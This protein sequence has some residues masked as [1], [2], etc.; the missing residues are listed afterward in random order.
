LA[1]GAGQ[2]Y[3]QQEIIK[4]HTDLVVID[5][6]VLKRK[7]GEIVNG[8]NAADFEL[9]ED[10]IRQQI[11]H[12]SQDQLSLSVILLIDLSGSVSP[13]LNEIRDGALVALNRLRE[14]DEVAVLAFST[15]TQL[16]QDF[17]TERR[18]VLNKISQ[19]DKTPLIGQGTLLYPALRD[20]AVHMSKASNPTSRRVIIA[21]TDN[22]SWDY[23]GF[24]VSEKE[25]SDQ[26]IGSG[27][28]VCGLVVEGSL[29]GVE[30]MLR[31]GG[32]GKDIYRR[33]MTIDPF[34]TQTGGEVIKSPSLEINA[35]LAQ[36]VD[37]LRTRYSLGF[38]PKR[39][40]ADGGYRQIRLIL[41]P[42]TN[43]RLGEVVIKTK[44][45]Y[46]ARP[47]GQRAQDVKPGQG[48]D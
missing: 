34:A 12:F 27:S 10:G 20:A 19:I 14:K 28:M 9:Y 25:V 47:R 11:T 1:A 43:K 33:R 40:Q 39:E 42:E 46:Y 36:L 35:R 16:V 6:Q 21:I 45:G 17:T 29:S 13:I 24:G 15:S 41:T 22:V 37:H 38:S 2:A 4:L 18:V 3:L 8:L 31:R 23:Y 5:A 48:I 7:T 30:K 32:D 26:V 44:Q